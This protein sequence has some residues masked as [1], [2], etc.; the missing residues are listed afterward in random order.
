LLG[1]SWSGEDEEA[2]NN[3]QAEPFADS[4]R[5]HALIDAS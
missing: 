4:F 1:G 2:R 5:V 3:K